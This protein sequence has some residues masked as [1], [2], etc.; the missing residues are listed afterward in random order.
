[1]WKLFLERIATSDVPRELLDAAIR[2][3]RWLSDAP[4]DH[5]DSEVLP[6]IVRGLLTSIAAIEDGRQVTQ[7]EAIE[8]VAPVV[9]RH[10][11]D[12]IPLPILVR[13]LHAGW[14][15]LWRSIYELAGDQDAAEVAALGLHMNDVLS[16]ISILM[17][18]TY[19]DTYSQLRATQEGAQ[20]SLTSALLAGEPAEDLAAVARVVLADAYTVLAI[21]VDDAA[22]P[23]GLIARRRARY[24]R[25]VLLEFGLTDVL[26]TFDGCAGVVLVPAQIIGSDDDIGDRSID[27]LVDALAD[28][29]AVDI[30]AS[31]RSAMLT[32]IPAAAAEAR[33]L[34]Q[35]ARQLNLSPQLYLIDDLLFEYQATRPGPAR[36]ALAELIVPLQEHD[37][38]LRALH[39][40][41]KYGADRKAAAAELFVHPNTF[42]YRLRRI[43]ELTGVDPTDPDGSRLFAAALVAHS[44]EHG[45]NPEPQATTVS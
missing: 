44:V 2:S 3:V 34:V 30:Y 8:W 40:H 41:L 21:A 5:F 1:M 45:E 9:E 43:R 17:T 37:G 27:S 23:H 20:Q 6:A 19:Q 18:E 22:E 28:R 14:A 11:E 25:A 29:L 12:G 13:G 33:E 35:L 36:S 42:T 15:H 4:T 24:A 39:L 32:T 31:V 26:S 38:L 7:A 10:A 16:T